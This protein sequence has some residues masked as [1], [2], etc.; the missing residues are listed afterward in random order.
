MKQS[1]EA[2]PTRVLDDTL[3]TAA[4]ETTLEGEEIGERQQ[5][6]GELC[7]PSP[8]SAIG[9]SKSNEEEDSHNTSRLEE[10]E[11][12]P[13]APSES[14]SSGVTSSG[15]D[16]SDNGDVSAITGDAGKVRAG[17]S[18]HEAEGGHAKAAPEEWVDRTTGKEQSS[19]T[20][21]TETGDE[22]VLGKEWDGGGECEEAAEAN[23]GKG[24]EVEEEERVGTPLDFELH[25]TEPAEPMR[26]D[27]CAIDSDSDND[28]SESGRSRGR[29]VAF[30]GMSPMEPLT[31]D[32]GDDGGGAPNVSLDSLPPNITL[33]PSSLPEPLLS[34]DR[35]QDGGSNAILLS[36][37][38]RP[39]PTRAERE[40]ERERRLEEPTGLSSLLH[41]DPDLDV[42]KTS[43]PIEP[44]DAL[45]PTPSLTRTPT[46]TPSVASS[47]NGTVASSGSGRRASAESI[48]SEVRLC[49]GHLEA[50]IKRSLQK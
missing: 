39:T 37:L 44:L 32:V 4:A 2:A 40:R 31:V 36:L 45:T 15:C 16:S 9:L 10:S 28:V 41:P 1:S 49:L 46:P 7:V 42:N 27:N 11:V 8:D 38:A 18:D 20:E 34:D 19:P 5:P 14:S 30:S 12:L 29:R 26:D 33:A 3:V 47:N 48:V 35:H 21:T 24:E 50:C 17:H 13:R 22:T 23:G 6:R 25:Y 43:T